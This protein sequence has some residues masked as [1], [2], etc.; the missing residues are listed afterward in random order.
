MFET[1]IEQLEFE[2]VIQPSK[3]SI[4]HCK[5]D[6]PFE[7][8]MYEIER[9]AVEVN[10]VLF[11]NERFRKVNTDRMLFVLNYPVIIKDSFSFEFDSS[12]TPFPETVKV[13]LFGKSQS[14]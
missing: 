1:T 14:F 3:R 6:K 11:D 13:T 8:K 7:I 10:S 5:V 2:F 4:L 9:D 12:K